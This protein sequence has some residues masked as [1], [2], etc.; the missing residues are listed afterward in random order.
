LLPSD[1]LPDVHT[2]LIMYKRLA[3]AETAEI[4]RELQ[5]EMIDRFG[6]LPDY[7]KNLIQI[8]EL[9]LK[10][11]PLGIRKID[12]GL[13]GGYFLFEDEPNIDPMKLVQL[14]QKQPQKYKLEGQHK[15]RLMWATGDFS[16][17]LQAVKT[18]LGVLG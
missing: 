4:L 11:T 2:R 13:E 16:D 3:N 1:Y 7:A 18:V 17:R 9:K 5:V 12:I 14:I 6:L 8:T 15:L 10:S